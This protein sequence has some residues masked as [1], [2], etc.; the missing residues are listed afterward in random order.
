[1]RHGLTAIARPGAGTVGATLALGIGV[2]VVLTMH[3]VGSRL[4]GQLRAELPTAAPTAFL[5]GIQ[6]EQWSGV[7]G[8]LEQAGATRVEVVPIVTAR[9]TKVDGRPVAQMTEDSRGGQ[10]GRGEH[11]RRW[12]L[13]RE[14]NLTY[15]ESLPAGNVVTEGALWRDPGRQEI[16]IEQDFARDLGVKL[17]SVLDFD[18]QGVP[19]HLTV[20]SLRRV[21]WRTFGINFFLIVEPG[22]LDHAPQARVAAMRLPPGSEQAVQDRLAAS[23]PNLVLLR[24]RE[25][26]DKVAA[27]LDRVAVGVR[28]VGSMTVLGGILILAGAVGA[29][30]VRRGRE[31]ALLKTLGMTRVGVAAVF[32]VEYALLGLVAGSI[33]ACAAE[34][35]AWAVLARWWEIEWSFRPLVFAGAILGTA[36]LAILA[37]LGASAGAMSRRP[38]EV[39]RDE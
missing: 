12:M 13:T 20:T 23:F 1:M 29:G 2:L 18:V 34:L 37:G 24:I 36:A 16:S 6:P 22:V 15:L 19:I 4:A 10:R 3:L 39:L 33:G 30:S 26:L 31:V 32:S 21:D 14:Q 27:I 9:L 35:L 11:D 38:V 17:G 7:R 5:V 25:V 8:I 28:A